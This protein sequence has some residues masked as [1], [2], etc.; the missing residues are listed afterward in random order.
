M[1]SVLWRG[2]RV[3]VAVHLSAADPLCR[4]LWGVGCAL[5]APTPHLCAPRQKKPATWSPTPLL[6][7]P[8]C[9]AVREASQGLGGWGRPRAACALVGTHKGTLDASPPPPASGE[10]PLRR[11]PG[12]GWTALP[13]SIRQKDAGLTVSGK[14]PISG[15]AVASLSGGLERRLGTPG[16]PSL[17]SGPVA[18]SSWRLP[19]PASSRRCAQPPGTGVWVPLGHGVALHLSWSQRWVNE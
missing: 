3:A 1:R 17:Q 5:T 19:G 10:E 14:T 4:V 13:D 8:S 6:H 11:R 2:C 15:R 9:T 18:A 7:P 12:R 16:P